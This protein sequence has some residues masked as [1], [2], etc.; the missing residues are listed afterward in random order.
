MADNIIHLYLKD[1]LVKIKMRQDL[2]PTHC[3]QIGALIQGGFYDSLKFHRVLDGFM[4][5]TGCPVGTGQAGISQNLT[6]EFT[7]EPHVRGTVSMARSQEPNSASTQFFICFKESKFLDN[8]YTVWGEVIE[9]MEFVDNIKLG[10]ANN[11]G[12]VVDPD[13]IVKMVMAG[14]DTV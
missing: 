2:A 8:Q 14:D 3:N 10:D 6:A 12:S 1:G 11:N 4:A 5:Q 13:R 7:S 9:G